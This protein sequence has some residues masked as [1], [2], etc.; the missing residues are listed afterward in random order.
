M[1]TKDD[2]KSLS[3]YSNDICISIYIPT[4][5]YGEETKNNVDQITLKNQL[6]SVTNKL[7]DKG[8]NQ[9]QIK[10][11]LRP[12]YQLLDDDDF[13]LH[14]SEGLALF[15][16]KD[17]FEK[18]TVP[19]NFVEFNYVSDHFYVKSLMPVFNDDENFYLLTLK[20]DEVNL[21]DCTRYSIEEIDINNLIPDDMKDRVGKDFEQKS[22]QFRSQGRQGLFHGH[23]DDKRDAKQELLQFFHEVDKGLMKVIGE[24]QKQPL[25]IASID[26]AFDL[27][28]ETNSYKNLYPDNVS[29]DPENQDIFLLH[30]KAT[31][32][33]DNY[34]K[35]EK[36]ENLKKLSDLLHTDK[37]SNA[38][39]EILSAVKQGKVESLV[40][41]NKQDLMGEYD[42]EKNEVKIHDNP[43]GS[44]KSLLNFAA[45]EVFKNGGNVYLIDKENLPEKAS[46]IN[47][48]YRY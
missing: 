40:L 38:L 7:E 23:G 21:Y 11:M 28:K 36:M 45:A 10:K 20:Q 48:V 29:G 18:F 39:E 14:Q 9:E 15:I 3:N 44:S 31:I 43:N 12:A 42:A 25:V 2:V 16:S 5:I 46:K 33:L 47:A 8:L 34:F 30:E 35:K 41:E 4:H 37:A 22:L 32:I 19:V 1:I 26:R 24:N 27:Y 6:K 17:K 13:W